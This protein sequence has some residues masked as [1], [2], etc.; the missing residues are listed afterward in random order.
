MTAEPVFVS[1]GQ[2]AQAVARRLNAAVNTLTAAIADL[3]TLRR[4]LTGVPGLTGALAVS[5]LW[6][7]QRA[8]DGASAARQVV[9]RQA[10]F[11]AAAAADWG[12]CD[13]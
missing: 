13:E 9:T 12:V 3:E 5:L 2:D 10:D 6:R 7:V 4:S 8:I 1:P 11:L